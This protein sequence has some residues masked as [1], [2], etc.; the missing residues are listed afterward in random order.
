MT[1]LKIGSKGPDVLALQ[2]KLK[3]AKF[4]PGPIDSIFGQKVL[5]AVEAYQYANKLTI[6]GIVGPE[7]DAALNQSTSAPTDPAPASAPFSLPWE[8]NYPTRTTWTQV[9]FKNIQ[10]SELAQLELADASILGADYHKMTEDA[11]IR[12]WCELCCRITLYESG[13][14]PLSVYHEPP[15]LGADSI[16]LF[17]LSYEDQKNYDLPIAISKSNNDLK[18]ALINIDVAVFIMKQLVTE[19]GRLAGMVDGKWHGLARYWSTMRDGKTAFNEIK[20]YLGGLK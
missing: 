5:D 7:T 3:N 18:N 8:I 10:S 6:D 9:L 19:N 14:N 13:Y 17:Q 11:R 16:G 2:V 20:R 15:P 12:R 4:D 1:T